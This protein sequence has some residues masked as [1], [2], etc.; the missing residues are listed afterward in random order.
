MACQARQHSDQMICHACGLVWDVNDPDAPDCGRKL[1]AM[2]VSLLQG[3]RRAA[4]VL[5]DR[6]LTDE[7][8]RQIKETLKNA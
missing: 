6:D 2:G 8:V 5:F 3:N 7:D 4:L 1:R